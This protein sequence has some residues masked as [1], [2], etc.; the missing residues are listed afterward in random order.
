VIED[1]KV[2]SRV[3]RIHRRFAFF[4]LCGSFWPVNLFV[5]GHSNLL[6][7]EMFKMQRERRRRFRHLLELRS[8]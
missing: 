7:V 5:G 6:Y 8:Q 2:M 3:C 1:R 4:D